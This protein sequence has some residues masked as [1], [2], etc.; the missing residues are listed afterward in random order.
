MLVIPKSKRAAPSLE[1][2]AAYLIERGLPKECLPER[3]VFTT[4]L[5]EPSGAS[6][7]A[8]PCVSGSS[9]RPVCSKQARRLMPDVLLR[10][11]CA[12]DNGCST[13]VR[14]TR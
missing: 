8:R 9:S 5:P 2:L 10:D 11:G 6:S 3:L 1:E 7:I 4:S 14:P 13:A 12:I